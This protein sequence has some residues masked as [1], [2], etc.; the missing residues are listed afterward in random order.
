MVALATAVVVAVTT[1]PLARLTPWLLERQPLRWIGLRS[2]GLYLWHW[3]VFMVTR[4]Y[5]DVA[6][7]GLPLLA[8]P[9]G[10]DFGRTLVT[11]LQRQGDKSA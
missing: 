4:P 6:L 2:Y 8:L 3:P 5:S 7:D 10:V 9:V 11:S 1:H